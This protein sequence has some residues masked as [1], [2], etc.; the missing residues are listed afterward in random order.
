MCTEMRIEKGV[1]KII[2]ALCADYKRRAD[3]V[4]DGSVSR[5]T[6]IEYKYLNY[7]ILDAATEAVGERYAMLYISEIGHSVG[8]AKSADEYISES[9]YTTRK[10]A[11]KQ[12][13]ARALHLVD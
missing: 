1:D 13:I 2:V 11:V 9:T 12:S 8:Y 7:K 4:E 6:E 3:A 10:A 5:R